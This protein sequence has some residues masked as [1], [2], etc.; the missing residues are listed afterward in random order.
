MSHESKGLNHIHLDILRQ[1]IDPVPHLDNQLRK[2]GSYFSLFLTLVDRNIAQERAEL[3]LLEKALLENDQ[4][5]DLR[6]RAGRKLFELFTT[7]ITAS[8]DNETELFLK[9]IPSESLEQ[10]GLV[11]EVVQSEIQKRIAERHRHGNPNHIPENTLTVFQA[12]DEDVLLVRE[13]Y[14]RSIEVR[15]NA[16]PRQLELNEAATYTL[17][18]NGQFERAGVSRF[19]PHYHDFIS[20][21]GGRTTVEI[22]HSVDGNKLPPIAPLIRESTWGDEV[23]SGEVAILVHHAEQNLITSPRYSY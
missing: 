14:T 11:D 18:K 20:F 8:G 17:N 4:D 3:I 13:V 23:S 15:I 1:K 19:D 22:R 6:E 16:E 12:P 9:P 7:A 21:D 10:D 5:I 2:Q